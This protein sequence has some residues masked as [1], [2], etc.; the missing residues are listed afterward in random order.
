MCNQTAATGV[1]S[2]YGTPRETGLP[3]LLRSPPGTATNRLVPLVGIRF[4]G[5]TGPGR[6]PG[7]ALGAD[8]DLSMW[9][10]PRLGGE[11]RLEVT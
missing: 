4:C 1:S 2:G 9:L 3:L 5:L 11:C 7:H 6:G 8:R 10:M